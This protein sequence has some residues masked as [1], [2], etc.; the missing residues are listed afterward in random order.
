MSAVEVEESEANQQQNKAIL[1]S[2]LRT[3]E[4]KK[5]KAKQKPAK[6]M[7]ETACSP[8]KD[9]ESDSS[10]ESVDLKQVQKD[11]KEAACDPMEKIRVQNV[12]S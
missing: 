10:I 9:Y 4:K 8:G 12:E 7:V 11:V 6:M 3:P 1:P 2:Q 5:R